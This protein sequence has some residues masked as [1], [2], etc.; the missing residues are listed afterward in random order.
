M[1]PALCGRSQARINAEG[2]INPIYGGDRMIIRWLGAFRH[3]GS[4]SDSLKWEL[5]QAETSALAAEKLYRGR[6]EIRKARVGL[7]VKNAA[8]LRRYYSDVWSKYNDKGKLV[9]TRHEG[10]AYSQHAECW[11]SP[12]YVG[13]VVKGTISPRAMRACVKASKQ[14]GLDML[15]LTR[16]GRLIAIAM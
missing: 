8:V 11:V 10:K 16:D 15:R 1:Q 6:S 13:I 12:S 3:K 5:E 9:K 2:F 4:L 7:L 14:Y